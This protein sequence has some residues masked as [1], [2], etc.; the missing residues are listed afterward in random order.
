[1]QH[2]FLLSGQHHPAGEFWPSHQH[3]ED[4]IGLR[5]LGETGRGAEADLQPAVRGP[6]Q[7]V[8]P[9]LVPAGVQGPRH[10]HRRHGARSHVGPAQT[11][12]PAGVRF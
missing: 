9:V 7:R 5:Y 2:L 3:P 11:Q 4:E 8:L 10:G 12:I 6:G 1:M